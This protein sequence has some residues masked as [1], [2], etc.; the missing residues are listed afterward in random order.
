MLTATYSK[1]GGF[2]ACLTSDEFIKQSPGQRQ[3]LVVNL[4]VWQCLLELL[5]AFVGVLGVAE[6]QAFEAG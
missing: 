4:A 2:L 3:R 6:R 1:M 5:H